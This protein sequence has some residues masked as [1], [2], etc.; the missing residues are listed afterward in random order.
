[1]EEGRKS[2]V[3]GENDKG[4]ARARWAVTGQKEPEDDDPRERDVDD[5]QQVERHPRVGK[6]LENLRPVG[7]EKIEGDVR[8]LSEQ[9]EQVEFLQVLP[10]PESIE[11]Q[12]DQQRRHRNAGKR[13][14]NSPVDPQVELAAE[15]GGDVI[16]VGENRSRDNREGRLFPSRFLRP[17]PGDQPPGQPVSHRIHER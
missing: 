2:D 3:C 16:G 13:V 11:Q 8:E 14:G 1:M 5:E 10:L 4:R 15:Q 12:G 17:G 7:I 9:R 6:R